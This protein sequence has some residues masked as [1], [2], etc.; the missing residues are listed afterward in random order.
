MYFCM[1]LRG[2]RS[3]SDVNV[4]KLIFLYT[5]TDILSLRKLLL[6]SAMNC[7]LPLR[8]WEL[9]TR[10]DLEPLSTDQVH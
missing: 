6:L 3:H 1:C 10:S 5:H 2:P 7:P 4:V 8:G 9:R